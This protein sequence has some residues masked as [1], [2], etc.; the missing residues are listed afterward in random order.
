MMASFG[1]L[2][3]A[4]E[5]DWPAAGVVTSA[6]SAIA[7]IGRKLAATGAVYAAHQLLQ[8]LHL[9]E[10]HTAVLAAPAVL[11]HLSHTYRTDRIRNRHALPDHH[12]NLPQLRDDLFRL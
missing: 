1:S 6:A 12:L 3:T 2:V 11:G 8:A 5:A 10:L 4:A 7:P 9:A